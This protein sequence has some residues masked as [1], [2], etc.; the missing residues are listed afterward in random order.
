MRNSIGVR[1]QRKCA[2]RKMN[3]LGTLL[4]HSNIVNSK[5]NIDIMKGELQMASVMAGTSAQKTDDVRKKK[6]KNDKES[7]ELAPESARK[8]EANVRNIAKRTVKE[9]YSLLLTIYNI[10]LTGSKL[11]KPD[12]VTHLEN[13]ISRDTGRY[14]R[15]IATLN[16]A[17]AS[18]ADQQEHADDEVEPANDIDVQQAGNDEQFIVEEEAV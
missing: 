11:Q 15:F 10:N 4:E 16:D 14:E 13:E 1:A 5:E 2:Q 18:G 17:S 3:Y 8:L 6:Q 12:F 9:I 7:A